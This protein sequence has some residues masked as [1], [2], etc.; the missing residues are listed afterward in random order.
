ME[1]SLQNVNVRKSASNVNNSDS[2]STSIK[3]ASNSQ[4]KYNHSFK[5]KTITLVKGTGLSERKV[6]T[7]MRAFFESKKQ[8]SSK[9][10]LDM[11]NTLHPVGIKK[12]KT[13]NNAKCNN[14]A[15]NL[16]VANKDDKSSTEE[17]QS[18]QKSKQKKRKNQVK[19]MTI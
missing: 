9:A 11:N 5:G 13:K 3:S 12:E 19:M 6:S 1:N 4:I 18:F 16:E 2:T 7:S 17:W 15:D 14:M 8:S 10:K